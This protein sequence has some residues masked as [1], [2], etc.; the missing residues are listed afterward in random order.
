MGLLASYKDYEEG[1]CLDAINGRE[2]EKELHY[3]QGKQ[4]MGRVKVGRRE[5]GV[6]FEPLTPAKPEVTSIAD[7]LLG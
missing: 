7:F 1:G 3:H 4:K 6:K 5:T 2:P